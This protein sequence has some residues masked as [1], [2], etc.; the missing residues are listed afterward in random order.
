[1]DTIFAAIDMTTAAAAIITIGVAAIGI[2]MAF[3]GTS[4]GK[5]AVKSV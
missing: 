2:R 3:K 5:Q 4:L 1:M